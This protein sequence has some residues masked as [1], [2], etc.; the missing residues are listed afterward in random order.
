MA[1]A[2]P[3]R[4]P[5]P[6]AE[7]QPLGMDVHTRLVNIAGR[8][9]M[10]SQRIV[11]MALLAAQGDVGAQ[12]QGREALELF[13]R[14]H[15]SLSAGGDGLPAPLAPALREAL[16]GH[17]GVD[18]AVLDFIRL[19]RRV[20]A[21]GGAPADALDRVVAQAGPM[22]QR[23]IALT[24][25]YEAQAQHDAQSQRR[26]R[27]ALIGA[28]QRI[29]GEARV[30]SMNARVAAARAGASGREF[31]VVAA[32]LLEISDEVETLSRRAIAD[33]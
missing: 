28:I 26:R 22:L 6:T 19:A 17:D 30:I 21:G 16:F 24:A 33:S 23:L 15:Q 2:S 20:L 11:L 32:R 4:P 27:A 14:S 13:A 25:V 12:R 5:A 10:L 31:A 29:A 18:A 3:I 1:L 7:A 8:Q 9:R